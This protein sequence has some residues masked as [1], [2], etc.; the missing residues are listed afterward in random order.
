MSRYQWPDVGRGATGEK[1][2]PAGRRNFM[3]PRRTDFDPEGARTAG[4]LG[5]LLAMEPGVKAPPSGR[6][7]LWQP[8]GPMTVISG[9]ATGTPRIAG[10]VNA[11]AIDTTGQRIYAASGNGG[12]WY[13]PD[14][15]A[16][17][18]SLGGFAPTE[19]PGTVNR[20]AQRNSCG[21][22]MVVFGASAANDDV[23]V[24]TGETSDVPNAQPGTSLGG[25]GILFSHGPAVS[26]S[27]NPWIREAK[28]L[29][30]AGVNR[31]VV[32]PGGSTIIAATTVG[33]RQRP[34]GGGVDVT[35]DK[36]AG[37]PFTDLEVECTDA[38]WT[39]GDG[40]RPARLWV[41]V[42]VGPK[43]GLWVRSG[44]DVNFKYVDTVGALRSRTVLAA[45]NPPNQ[46]YL[47]NDGGSG[48]TP[49]LFRIAAA[50]AALPVATMVSAVPDVL[51]DQG[52]YDI[53]IAV[54]PSMP[55][56]VVLGGC[57]FTARTPDGTDL[58]DG[59]VVMGDVSAVGGNLTFGQPPPIRAV[60]VG[61]HS[62]VHSVAFSNNG[63]RLWATCDGGVY[64]SEAPIKQ[65]AFVPCNN[66]LSI[67]EA[68]YIAC[69][70]TCEGHVA[71]GLQD[72]GVITRISNGVWRNAGLGDGG[73][74][75]FDPVRP[76]RFLRQHFRA[77]WSSS[78]GLAAEAFLTRAGTFAQ[79]EFDASAF[80]STAAAIAKRR[81]VV[82]PAP[83]DVRQIIVG[84]TRVWYTEDFG[85][86]W[87]TL[88]TGNDPLP[89]NQGQDAFGEK[90]TVC[91]WQSPDVAWI[92]GEQTLKRY[93]RAANSDPLVGPGTWSIDP[94]P[95]TGVKPK[96]PKDAP[97]PQAPLHGS[98][99][100]TD[101]AV[102]LQGP[103]IDDFPPATLGSK[104]A[105]YLGTIGNP[106]NEDID[107]LWWFDGE[108]TWHSTG[109][110]KSGTGVPAPVTAI[111]C[112]PVHPEEVWVG[113][114][115]GVWLGIRTLHGSDPPTWEWSARVNGLP[116][117][118]VEDLAIFSDGGIRLLRAAIA[119]RGAWELQLDV[120]ET[121]DLTY[122]RA[123]DDDLRYRTRAV[124]KKRDLVT[125][126]SW[127]G[128]PDVRPRRAPLPRTAPGTLPW[129]QTTPAIEAEGLR[130]FQAALRAR[131]GD[132]RV[133]ATGAWDSY[134]N[135]VLRDLG[136]PLRPAP[137]F[138]AN[139]VGINAN[140]WNLS[141]QVPHQT[142]EPWG[143]VAPKEADLYDLSAALT[144]GDLKRA[145]CELP[146]AAMKVD[147]I[148]HRRGLDPID[149]ANVRVTLLK[150]IDPKTK[151]AAKWDNNATWFSGNVP[152][153][154]AVNQVLNSGDGKTALALDNGWSFVLGGDTESHRLTLA[155][156]T[157]DS[158]HSGIAT[159]D[160]PT[161]GLK[162]N[163]LVLLVAIVR[164]GTT[165]ADDIA[166]PVK[167][168]QDL[169]LTSSNVAVRSMRIL[170]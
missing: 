119:S 153:T 111:V 143:A 21:A 50:T 9:Q 139:T 155:G 5:A 92:L 141:M 76:D 80:Y 38:L 43:A 68:N 151:N 128:S 146:L 78:D 15:G 120:A 130:R 105:I 115:V 70:P 142:A 54:H 159:F 156:Q 93:V 56:R 136:A 97:P 53:A 79:A 27:D 123:H 104:G 66:G 131:T 107:T 77:F 150:W 83:P 8:L 67:V 127:H 124:E 161:T 25:I 134:F 162:K 45:S 18:K 69:H 100:W 149:G 36:V 113:T 85:Q 6:Q 57:T 74:I 135:E 132:E 17:W 26:N 30:G 170:P 125:D 48:T 2:D 164:A 148:V 137:P 65:V 29:L 126:R 166:L 33:L 14:A 95:L 39:A 163:G 98:K 52:F 46:I 41:W 89:A 102:N 106:D 24:G 49:N 23:Y 47:L 103:P 94:V 35:W 91:R 63:N 167:S 86:N 60:G 147:I 158:T 117:A 82:A 121:K 140:F 16:N 22:I 19:A 12:V 169:A 13:S 58:T 81:N 138:P 20:P 101:I 133:R 62:D 32:E 96:K 114:T 7:H 61:V 118:P 110:R 157:L 40:P 4:H 44:A 71:T 51:Q 152:W 37:T 1:D 87:V 122:V 55:D 10:R 64:R 165:A 31:I 73:G 42:R 88:P 154:A 109:L 11:L 84:T 145:S 99:V 90:I 168:L 129:S 3:R 28:N 75:V 160:L 116:E 112:D 34:A 72:N 59:A 144:E 108:S